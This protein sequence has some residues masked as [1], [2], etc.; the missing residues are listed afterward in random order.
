[1]ESSRGV[2][3]LGGQDCNQ[4]YAI[5]YVSILLIIVGLILII[6]GA[7]LCEPRE[8]ASRASARAGSHTHFPTRRAHS[9]CERPPRWPP[10]IP[11]RFLS[12]TSRSTS[13][14]RIR[15]R[16]FGYA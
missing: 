13:S 5:F 14:R 9:P 15:R 6:L 4:V 12:A 8:T 3:W 11:S 1:M 16:V 10:F 7:A 2:F